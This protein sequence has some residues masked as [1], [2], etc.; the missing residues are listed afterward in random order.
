MGV[1]LPLHA[2]ADRAPTGEWAPTPTWPSWALD[3]GVGRRA[4]SAR[5]RSTPPSSVSRSEPSP[6]LPVSR[7]GWNE[8]FVDPAAL[9]E[10]AVSA[11]AREL[12]GSGRWCREL[13]AAR[14]APLV[15]YSAVRRRAPIGARAHGRGPL[16]R[17]VGPS[18]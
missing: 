7:L 14:R 17:A 10:L 1:F 9:P 12:L 13:E 4:S 3:A 8:M 11:R 18:G 16:R 2:P 15:D 6:Y 5:S